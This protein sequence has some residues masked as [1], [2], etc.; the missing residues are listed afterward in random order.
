[1]VEDKV[2]ELLTPFLRRMYSDR[3]LSETEIDYMLEY[4]VSAAF[5][6]LAKWFRDQDMTGDE[7]VHLLVTISQRGVLSMLNGDL[8]TEAAS[9]ERN[10]EQEVLEAILHDLRER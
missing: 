3:D 7:M 10:S 6:A 5:G 8:V 1:M 2:K 4:Q 9:K